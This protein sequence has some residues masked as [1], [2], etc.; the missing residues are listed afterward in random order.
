MWFIFLQEV[1]PPNQYLHLSLHLRQMCGHK[2]KENLLDNY[3]V[4]KTGV[5][6]VFF[7]IFYLDF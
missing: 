2:T 7:H 4:R 1:D 6:Q 5:D 3:S